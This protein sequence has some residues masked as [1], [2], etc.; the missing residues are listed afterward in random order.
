MSRLISPLHG[1]E[2]KESRPSQNKWF[3]SRSAKEI[4]F[5]AWKKGFMSDFIIRSMLIKL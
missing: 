5:D 2:R 4:Q 3:V 1:K